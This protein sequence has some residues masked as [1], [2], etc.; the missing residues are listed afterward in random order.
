MAKLSEK[1]TAWL[2]ELEEDPDAVRTT[3][4]SKIFIS[5]GRTNLTLQAIDCQK[6]FQSTETVEALFD[7]LGRP[8]EAILELTD[9]TLESDVQ[10]L[11]QEMFSQV[12]ER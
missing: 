9:V 12:N 2:G 11:L 6:A 3:S 4:R 5:I 10:D 7:L 1:L 8:E